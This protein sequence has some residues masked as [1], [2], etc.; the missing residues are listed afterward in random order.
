MWISVFGNVRGGGELWQLCKTI[1]K[2]SVNSQMYLWWSIWAGTPYSHPHQILTANCCPSTTENAMKTRFWETGVGMT[3]VS[4]EHKKVLSW[5]TCWD[6]IPRHAQELFLLKDV[7]RRPLQNVVWDQQE[8]LY[9]Q[10]LWHHQKRSISVACPFQAIHPCRRLHVWAFLTLVLRIWL[11]NNIKAL[12]VGEKHVH[13][14]IGRTSLG[15]N[16]TKN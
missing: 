13:A 1:Q 7:S 3:W 15:G 14:K 8:L 11:R 2:G 10:E 6:E 9:A 16:N 4:V 12:K 5:S